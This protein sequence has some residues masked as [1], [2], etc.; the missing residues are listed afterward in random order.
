MGSLMAQM[1]AAARVDE[2]V[3][4]EA[5]AEPKAKKLSRISLKKISADK[6]FYRLKNDK[7]YCA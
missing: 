3:N 5:I 6:R 1:A 4:P 2:T 7:Q